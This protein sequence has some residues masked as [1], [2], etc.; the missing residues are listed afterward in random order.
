MN[1]R[2]TNIQKLEATLA[3]ARAIADAV[4]ELGS[5]PAGHLYV[6]LMDKISLQSFEGVIGL[7]VRSELVRRDGSHLLTWI[8]PAK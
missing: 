1:E 3:V 8:G 4:R 5:V 2:E 7:L 6:R